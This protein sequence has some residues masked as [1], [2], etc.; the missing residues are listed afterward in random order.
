MVEFL[1]ALAAFHERKQ[2]AELG[3]RSLFVYLH[4]ELK[5]S[6]AAAFYRKSVVELM[7]KFPEVVAPLRDGRL[8]MTAVVEL[9]KVLTAENIGAVLPRYFHCSKREAQALTVEMAPVAEPPVRDVILEVH[10]GEP[11][12]PPAT[13]AAPSSRD[14]AEPMTASLS[15]LH[16]T[17]SREFLGVLEQ[18]K[19]ALGHK[20]PSGRLEEVFGEG[21]RLILREHA[22]RK[23][24]T[25]R[26]RPRPVTKSAGR[27][28][29]AEVKRAVWMRDQGRCQWPLAGGGICAS[30]VR[31]ELDHVQAWALGG[32]T[33][34]ENLQ[35][36]CR[37]HNDLAAQ[38]TFGEKFMAQFKRKP[39]S[40]APPR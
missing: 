16:L 18:A 34:V 3:Y 10:P 38:Q 28:L 39:A 25:E 21:L 12:P 7:L 32:E 40:H 27:R 33:T 35:L 37:F 5:L 14:Q 36:L 6:K 9:A 8:C 4:E 30:T 11:I 1:L 19:A 24:L 13:T 23:G 31:V 17:V 15:R 29:P 20:F 2:W 26:P 22:K